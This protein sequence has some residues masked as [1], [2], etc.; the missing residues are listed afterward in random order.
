[1]RK[2]RKVRAL[3]CWAAARS[4]WFLSTSQRAV[5]TTAG[6]FNREARLAAPR[7]P[8]P[9]MARRRVLAGDWARR[10][11]GKPRAVVVVVRKWRREVGMGRRTVGGGGVLR[12]VGGP[13]KGGTTVR[14]LAGGWGQLEREDEDEDEEEEEEEEE[15]DEEE[16]GWW[17]FWFEGEWIWGMKGVWMRRFQRMLLCRGGRFL[18]RRR[19]W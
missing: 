1:L 7:P 12:G 10:R 19:G 5:M 13:P 15:E 11:A 3:G 6:S 4:R 18:V 17:G 8:Q 9:M 2:S 14:G 16:E